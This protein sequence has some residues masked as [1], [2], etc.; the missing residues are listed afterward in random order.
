VAEPTLE[1]R[2]HRSG[3]VMQDQ[4][5][6]TPLDLAPGWPRHQRR[7]LRLSFAAIAVA[8]VLVVA[9]SILF[10]SGRD[11][12]SDGIRSGGPGVRERPLDTVPEGVSLI[13]VDGQPVFLV[14]EGRK[15]TAFIADVRHLSGEPL[16]WC[17][18]ERVFVAPTHGEEFDGAGR[19]IGGPARGDLNRFPTRV[20]GSQL[21]ID[22]NQIVVGSR[23]I[24][25]GSAA[26]AGDGRPWDAGPGS[27]CAGAL[28]S[29]AAS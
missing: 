24:D 11:V 1:E 29:P 26:E 20:E 3:D 17:P 16:W 25:G 10:R 6:A 12:D 23:V 19:K 5:R 22:A 7:R 27:F 21:L 14:R 13:D 4:L 15:V 2:L 9:V 18:T 28:R 8:C